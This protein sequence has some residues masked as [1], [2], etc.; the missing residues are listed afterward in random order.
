[1]RR[2]G[3][4]LHTSRAN[5]TK[6]SADLESVVKT[7]HDA[8]VDALITIGGD[9]TAFSAFSVAK[10]AQEV[11]HINLKSVHIPKTI[12]NDLPL[13]E[14]VPT[15]GFETARE[16][17]TRIVMNLKRDAATSY[18]WFLVLSMGRQSGHLAL[19]IGQGALATITLIPEEWGGKEI[20]LQSV[21]DILVM[22]ML[23]RSL[24]GKPY[25]VAVIAEG[26]LENLSHEDLQ[27]LENVERDEHQHIR[28]ANINFLD[29][30]KQAMEKDLADLGIKHKIVKHTLGYELRCAPPCAY[31]IEYTRGL[32]GSAVAF[33]LNGGSNAI[34]SQQHG[35]IVPLPYDQMINPET[36]RTVVR[37][38]NLESFKYKSAYKF[39]TRLKAEHAHQDGLLDELASLTKLDAASFKNRYGYLL[40]EVN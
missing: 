22:S 8:G 25:G 17:G 33:I 39:M 40:N 15:F 7:L 36:G 27:T 34:I 19:G 9:D 24:Q 29:V 23:I 4:I 26:I 30:L 13:P 37:M 18:Q 1:M 6:T 21:V 32:G 14:D 11:M 2:G 12:D 5:P 28:L 10:Y 16:T 3:S 20:R 35:Q 38:V 31:D